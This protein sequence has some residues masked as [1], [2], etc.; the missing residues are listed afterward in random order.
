MSS[1]APFPTEGNF[2]WLHGHMEIF[3]WNRKCTLHVTIVIWQ[4]TG[5][6]TV[7]YQTTVNCINVI[8]PQMRSGGFNALQVLYLGGIMMSWG[9]VMEVCYCKVVL[10]TLVLWMLGSCGSWFAIFWWWWIYES[11]G[12]GVKSFWLVVLVKVFECLIFNCKLLVVFFSRV[13]QPQLISKICR[14]HIDTFISSRIQGCFVPL[15]TSVHSPLVHYHIRNVV[16]Y[17]TMTLMSLGREMNSCDFAFCCAVDI[18]S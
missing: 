11:L 17:C 16:K 8:I 4:L 6:L 13:W 12:A 5:Q 14:P 15:F 7:G 3:L 2:L 18:N 1:V 10:F 9:E